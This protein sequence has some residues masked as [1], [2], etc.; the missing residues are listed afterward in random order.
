MLEAEDDGDRRFVARNARGTVVCCTCGGLAGAVWTRGGDKYAQKCACKRSAKVRRWATFDFNCVAE[1][2][3][4]CAATLVPSGWRGLPLY[5][6]PCHRLVE[7]ANVAFADDPQ[8]APYIPIGRQS[9]SHGIYHRG[10]S[11]ASAPRDYTLAAEDLWRR[12]DRVWS[13]RR[14]RGRA[15]FEALG[16][17]TDVATELYLA[18]ARAM[19]TREAGVAALRGELVEHGPAPGPAS[20]DRFSCDA[21]LR[22]S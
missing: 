2:C 1:V 6:G 17:S 20:I 10:A 8:P 22:R 7:A 16:S 18:Q 12:L 13:F 15:V 9:L 14:A 5:C 4:A 11:E 3:A 21:A 19:F